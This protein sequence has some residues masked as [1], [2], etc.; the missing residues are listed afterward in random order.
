MRRARCQSTRRASWSALR[1]GRGRNLRRGTMVKPKQA[2]TLL[3]PLG[4]SLWQH[5]STGAGPSAQAR[6]N[7][8]SDTRPET[9]IR[10]LLHRRGRRFRK[11]P[12]IRL[13]DV[14]VRPDIAFPGRRVAVF[15]DGCFWHGCPEHGR[16]PRSNADYWSAKL[17]RNV[18]RDNV[19]NQHLVA[20]G[21]TVVRIWEHEAVAN[22]AERVIAALEAVD[23]AGPSE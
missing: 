11:D 21:W 23:A 16:V 9:A 18:A 19:V 15:V 10:S 1:C 8:R 7:R 22:A 5:E 20:A 4:R 2:R 3:P 12:S 17:G 13:G 14:R 6:G